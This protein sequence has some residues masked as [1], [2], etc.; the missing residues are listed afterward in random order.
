MKKSELRQIIKE[1]LSKL[2]NENRT[3]VGDTVKVNFSQFAT[4]KRLARFEDK[5][6]KVVNILDKA[7]GRIIEIRPIGDYQKEFD[8][9]AK[10]AQQPYP[11]LE[12][13]ITPNN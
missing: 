7:N 12:K 3:S 6:F 11:V 2:L 5:P 10:T 9:M 1:E 8:M 4:D 13:F